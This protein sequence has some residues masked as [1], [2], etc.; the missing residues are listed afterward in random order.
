M[1]T[2]TP[3]RRIESWRRSQRSVSARAASLII[4]RQHEQL[5][6][7]C[8]ARN[9]W[10]SAAPGL[11]GS[12]T[13]DAL[14]EGGRRARSSS[15]TISCA[16]RTKTS[17]ARCK[18]PARED[19]RG[20]RRHLPDRHPRRGAEGHRRRVPLRRAV[21][22]AVPRVS[23]RRVRRQRPRHVQR[24]RSLRARTASSGWSTPRRPR[25]TATRSKSR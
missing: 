16:A 5:R 9:F 18:R 8:A 24:A 4:A 7:T 1:P 23:A 14:L 11:I 2:W 6:W 10:S 13:V 19:L 20:R 15:T 12:H 22:A 17:R 3:R 25:S 21:A